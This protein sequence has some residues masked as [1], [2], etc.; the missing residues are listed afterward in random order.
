MPMNAEQRQMLQSLL[1]SR[2]GLK[3]HNE[4]REG[5]VYFLEK[6]KGGL[7]KAVK[8]TEPKDQGNVPRMI[9]VRY[10]GSD[11]K[12]Q[13]PL[14]GRNTTMAYV[15]QRLSDYLH[16]PVIDQTGIEGAFDFDIPGT[17][18]LETDILTATFGEVKE[19]GLTLKAGKGPVQTIVVDSATRPTEN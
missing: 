10:G 4:S 17:T 5:P 14:Y 11:V 2:F 19:L 7:T 6:S 18:D 8:P 12:E 15:A 3:Y 1:I 16:H 9:V 13:Y